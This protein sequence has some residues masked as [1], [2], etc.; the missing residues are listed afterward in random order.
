M[1][2]AL[3]GAVSRQ[4]EGKQRYNMHDLDHVLLLESIWPL[5]HALDTAIG[6]FQVV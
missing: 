6:V 3:R 2:T 5:E 4:V 1:L